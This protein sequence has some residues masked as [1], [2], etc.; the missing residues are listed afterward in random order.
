M[1][2]PSDPNHCAPMGPSLHRPIT[3][4]GRLCPGPQTGS[5]FSLTPVPALP[6]GC[7]SGAS[8]SMSASTAEVAA[9]RQRSSCSAGASSSAASTPEAGP[10]SWQALRSCRHARGT[11][12]S[13]GL[14]GKR[15][16]VT[17]R[18]APHSSPRQAPAPGRPSGP[19]G[20]HTCP[21]NSTSGGLL[22]W[23]WSARTGTAL[24][25]ALGGPLLLAG[26]QVLRACP[27]CQGRSA[28]GGLAAGVALVLVH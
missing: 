19:A 2:L 20:T 14:L 9:P 25:Q 4:H 23:Q 3:L 21:G 11:R 16:P 24:H 13:C 1:S 10:C 7:C 18:T 17:T 5:T 15:W 26:P 28:S 22:D 6:G 8:L 12:A 27:A